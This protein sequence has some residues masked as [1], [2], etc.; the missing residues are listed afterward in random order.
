MDL[1]R[2]TF[3]PLQHSGHHNQ[4]M[5]TV[6]ARRCQ[7]ALTG[8]DGVGV[9]LIQPVRMGWVGDCVVLQ[10]VQQHEQVMCSPEFDPVGAEYRFE[11]LFDRLLGVKTHNAIANGGAG[12]EQLTSQL[13]LARRSQQHL[14][15]RLMLLSHTQRGLL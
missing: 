3:R 12:S 8:F 7:D 2:Q 13:V 5:R 1:R 9:E 6:Q 10:Q 11:R 4:R 14:R 15:H